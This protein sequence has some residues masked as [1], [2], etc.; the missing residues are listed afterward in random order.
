M[1]FQKI[2]PSPTGSFKLVAS[3]FLLF[4]VLSFFAVSSHAQGPQG[5]SFGFGLIVGD[6]LG[7]TVKYW[8][9]ASNAL[10]I[11]VGGSYFGSPRV[12]VDYLFNF[13]A[14]RSDVVTMYAGPGL[15]VG[16]GQGNTIF[17]KRDGEKFYVREGTTSGV[18]ARVIFGL[19]IIPRNSP[20]ELFLEAGP[21]IGISPGFGVA[22]DAGLGIRFYP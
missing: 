3:M 6:P 19:N 12:D 16:F 20:I 18:A 14:F 8:P 22:M 13:N 11:D 21:L 2:T 4:S 1:Q 5:K 15:A 10:V 7:A 9:S 17:Y